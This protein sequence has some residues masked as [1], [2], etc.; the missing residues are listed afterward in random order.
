[1]L[2]L[3]SQLKFI[4]SILS[5]KKL[6][7]PQDKNSSNI[8]FKNRYFKLNKFSK[9]TLNK[10]LNSN[11]PR[12]KFNK[13]KNHI[14]SLLRNKHFFKKLLTYS[15]F[16]Y[17]Q[18]KRLTFNFIQ[19]IK[20]FRYR[21]NK[22]IR[23]TIN[24]K[25]KPKRFSKWKHKKPYIYMNIQKFQ[26][27]IKSN[28]L[29]LLD[30]YFDQYLQPFT[31]YKKRNKRSQFFFKSPKLKKNSYFKTL[32]HTS[33]SSLS[34]LSPPILTKSQ[35]YLNYKIHKVQF[36]KFN[37]KPLPTINF[38]KISYLNLSSCINL[39]I[40]NHRN[41]IKYYRPKNFFNKKLFLDTYLTDK[42][43]VYFIKNISEKKKKIFN[44]LNKFITPI[45]T[46][47]LNIKSKPKIKIIRKN[48]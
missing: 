20:F 47:T 17:K 22:N 29:T 23:L 44:N 5:S 35:I 43:K 9:N 16:L 21:K 1:M 26:N 27:S 36:L 8:I 2:F 41:Y 45:T 48:Q 14:Y 19:F 40:F 12:Y 25:N 11:Y 42:I 6:Q 30:S 13:T 38:N 32:K 15:K 37:V 10:T 33:I 34:Q 18:K 3:K 46:K 4:K 7:F 28:N 24:E 31:V 39:N